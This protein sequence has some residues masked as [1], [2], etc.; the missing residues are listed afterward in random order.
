MKNIQNKQTSRTDICNQGNSSSTT[1]CKNHT[2]VG[3]L[4]NLLHI[5]LT[6]LSSYFPRYTRADP[7]EKY[8]LYN[9]RVIHAIKHKKHTRDPFQP[10]RI[11]AQGF[12][13]VV[14]QAW[15]LVSTRSWLNGIMYTTFLSSCWMEST[16]IR[17][18]L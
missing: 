10:Q 3:S 9:F 2:L 7:P 1:I 17:T 6:S 16:T 18:V 13:D 5:E 11:E 4:L 8:L 12:L 15:Y 14:I